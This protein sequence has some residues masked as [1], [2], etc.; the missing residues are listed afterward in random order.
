MRWN[1]WALVVLGLWAIL[2][3]WILGFS[4]LNLILW[5]SI[6][7]GALIIVFAFWNFAPPEE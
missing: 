3:P 1:E 4:G 2:S 6:L 7:I 5:N